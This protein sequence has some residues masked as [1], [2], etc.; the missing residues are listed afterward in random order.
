M[1]I[2]SI[3][4]SFEGQHVAMIQRNAIRSWKTIAEE[5]I[6]FGDEQGVAEAC[7]MYG[8]LHY[9]EIELKDGVPLMDRAFSVAQHYHRHTNA[10]PYLMYVNADIIVVDHPPSGNVYQHFGT[11]EGILIV[12]QRWNWKY[13]EPIS[14]WSGW[15]DSLW[16]RAQANGWLDPPV[17]IDYF[18]FKAGQYP[19]F[20]PFAIG[21]YCSDTF[22]VADSIKRGIRVVDATQVMRVVHQD[23]ESFRNPRKSPLATYNRELVDD[24]DLL[25]KG[26][27]DLAPYYLDEEYNICEREAA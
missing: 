17:A 10:T 16:R 1:I 4:K 5:V 7:G 26:R 24:Q 19:D 13:P 8:C 21:R 6:L 2:F 22:L 9:P 3:P 23:H 12:G 25:V 15:R 27:T 18:Y 20:P 11:D 14:F